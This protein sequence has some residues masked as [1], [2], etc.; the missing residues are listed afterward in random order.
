MSRA[1]LQPFLAQ[2]KSALSARGVRRV[3]WSIDVDPQEV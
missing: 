1:G 3:R 2:W